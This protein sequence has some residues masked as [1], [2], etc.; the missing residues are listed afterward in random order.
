M[1]GL[2]RPPSRAG[3]PSGAASAARAAPAR[4]PLQT[5]QQ[6]DR[7]PA[8]ARCSQC[9]CACGISHLRFGP[10]VADYTSHA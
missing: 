8:S 5:A 6:V 3:G 1:P 7:T 4:A 2:R 9:S 10:S